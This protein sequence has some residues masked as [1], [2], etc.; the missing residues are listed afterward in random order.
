MTATNDNPLR[1]SNLDSTVSLNLK[2]E[3]PTLKD[4]KD[5]ITTDTSVL[6]CFRQ[7]TS[8][9]KSKLYSC[10]LAH[11]ESYLSFDLGQLPEKKVIKHGTADLLGDGIPYFCTSSF[12]YMVVLYRA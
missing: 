11:L 3:S 12:P 6:S 2:T 10:F 8:V 1:S 4:R 9:T 5:A 7:P